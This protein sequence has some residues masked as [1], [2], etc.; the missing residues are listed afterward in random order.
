MRGRQMAI[1]SIFSSSCSLHASSM[2][3][4]LGS[5]SVQKAWRECAWPSPS[6]QLRRS[7]RS[8]RHSVRFHS[9]TG[10]VPIASI[11]ASLGVPIS[12]GC[13]RSRCIIGA[14]A[15]TSWSARSR[16]CSEASN[17]RTRCSRFAICRCCFVSTP[18]AQ[19]GWAAIAESS[20]TSFSALFA[21]V[22]SRGGASAIADVR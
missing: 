11:A 6:V 8:A 5:A 16:I 4:P 1:L 22:G 18:T 17:S 19:V 3:T 13:S 14:M 7:R 10:V 15:S 12:Y 9:S 2:A 21:S 20:A